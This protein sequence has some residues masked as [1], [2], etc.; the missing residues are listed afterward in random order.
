MLILKFI[1]IIFIVSSFDCDY[2][3]IFTIRDIKMYFFTVFN[4]L[5]FTPRFISGG[6]QEWIYFVQVLLIQFTVVFL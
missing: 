5:Y 3:C 6:C 1:V 4:G 2:N